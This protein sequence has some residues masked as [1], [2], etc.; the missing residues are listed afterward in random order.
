MRYLFLHNAS[1][2]SAYYQSSLMLYS[3]LAMGTSFHLGQVPLLG[4]LCLSL[5]KE[6]PSYLVQEMGETLYSRYYC[7][8]PSFAELMGTA[9]YLDLDLEMPWTASLRIMM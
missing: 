2:S 1:Q 4:S 5:E 8:R 9:F 6:N 7:F 3:Q